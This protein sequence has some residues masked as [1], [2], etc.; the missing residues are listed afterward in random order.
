MAH[1]CLVFW[2]LQVPIFQPGFL[3]FDVL[4]SHSPAS[5]CWCFVC[6]CVHVC[7]REQEAILKLNTFQTNASVLQK[8]R[9]KGI[10]MTKAIP[11]TK[12]FL[13]RINVSVSKVTAHKHTKGA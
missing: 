6:V 7:E 12:D 5:S 9:R 13:R 1:V 3:G 8:Q 10:D 2:A 4:A 11:L